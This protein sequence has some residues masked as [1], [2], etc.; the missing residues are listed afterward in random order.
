MPAASG[1]KIL[2]KSI[3]LQDPDL[4]FLSVATRK[5]FALH[6]AKIFTAVLRS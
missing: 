4:F 3:P 2:K 5:I 6:E 1:S